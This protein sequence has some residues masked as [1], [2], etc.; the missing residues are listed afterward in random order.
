MV[1]IPAFL[2]AHLF[3]RQKRSSRGDANR[4]GAGWWL[5]WGEGDAERGVAE[6]SEEAFGDLDQVEV[7]Q[8]VGRPLSASGGEPRGECV[9]A[10]L[11][12]GDN[13]G[14]TGRATAQ[15]GEQRVDDAEQ[16]AAVVAGRDEP[17]ARPDPA[18]GIF[19]V[20]E[21]VLARGDLTSED[22]AA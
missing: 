16:L 7:F 5:R 6:E 19:R 2:S 4:G 10:Y 13:L 8:L 12:V 9:D 15:E 20:Q 22:G 21:G 11:T 1:G 14:P 18:L 3:P 17:V